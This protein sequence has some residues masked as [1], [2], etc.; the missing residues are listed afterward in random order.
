LVKHG[1]PQTLDW[2]H[3]GAISQVEKEGSIRLFINKTYVVKK[4]KVKT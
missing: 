2:T 3:T 1:S 4:K